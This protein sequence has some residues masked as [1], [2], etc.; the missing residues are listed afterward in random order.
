MPVNLPATVKKFIGTGRRYTIS[1]DLTGVP[2]TGQ[3]PGKTGTRC[4]S[5]RL[6]CFRKRNPENEHHCARLK[7]WITELRHC[8]GRFRW[9]DS[10]LTLAAPESG[11]RLCWRLTR[12]VIRQSAGYYLG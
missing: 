9:L 10:N 4:E 8:S 5:A 12:H 1:Q 3:K 7:E 6:R 2:K 11:A